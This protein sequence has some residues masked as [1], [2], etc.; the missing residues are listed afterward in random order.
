MN[1]KTIKMLLAIT[2]ALTWRAQAQILTNTNCIDNEY[3]EQ[4]GTLQIVSATGRLS[5]ISGSNK[6]LYVSPGAALTGTVTLSADNITPGGDVVPLIYTPSWG[7]DSNSWQLINGGIPVG[8]STQQAQVSVTVP[9]TPGTYYIIFAF[10]WE[11]TGDQV[12]SGSNWKL[13]NDAWD[14]GNDIAEFSASQIASAQ[15]NGYA[16]DEWLFPGTGGTTHYASEY[17]P[18]DGITLIVGSVTPPAPQQATAIAVETNSFIVG[19]NLTDGGYGYTNTPSVQIIGGG[20]SGAEAV[21]VVSNGVVIAVNVLEAGD[22]YTNAPIVLIAPPFIF[23]PVLEIAPMSFLTF[24]NL[25][26]FGVYQLQQ[27]AEGYYWTNLPVN[28]EATNA[29]YTQMLAG[30]ANSGDY[31]LALAPVPAQAFAVADVTNGLVFG[32]TVTSGGSG[33]ITNPP[34]S[35]VGLGTNAGGISQ[36][37]GGVVT[38]ITITNAGSGYTN[39]TTVEIGPPPAA[40]VSPTVQLAMQVDSTSL[41]PY[42][43]YQIQ[44]T[45]TI[46]TPWANWNGGLFSPTYVTNSQYLFVTNATGFFRLQY[47]P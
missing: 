20:G 23:N 9:S 36:I 46:G 41:V 11:E 34:V 38:S 17:I 37:S 16:V 18:S 43:N 27:L 1:P 30:V 8:Q 26:V 33:Y 39:T 44:F 24:S 19:V 42:D 4:G 14:D 25:T 31:R 6:I 15:L 12:A 10:S 35:I 22:G 32:A 2:V 45:P 21:A 29:L 40:A 7:A 5:S 3:C 13:G 28:F 47:V